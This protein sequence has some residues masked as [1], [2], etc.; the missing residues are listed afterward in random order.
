[1]DIRICLYARL[2]V[3]YWCREKLE[4]RVSTVGREGKPREDSQTVGGF[5]T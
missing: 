5:R 1:M 2:I 4:R 3:D